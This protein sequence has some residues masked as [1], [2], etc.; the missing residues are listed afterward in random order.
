VEVENPNVVLRSLRG[1]ASSLQAMCNAKEI[2]SSLVLRRDDKKALRDIKEQHGRVKCKKGTA[3]QM[4]I[5]LGSVPGLD[6]AGIVTIAGTVSTV[7]DMAFQ[8]VQVGCTPVP[9][10][11][12]AFICF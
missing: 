1:C 4:I 7:V 12:S 11:A 5:F 2:V 10:T 9:A 3:G 6:C 8:L